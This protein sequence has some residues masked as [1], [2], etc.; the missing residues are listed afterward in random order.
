MAK[1]FFYSMVLMSNALLPSLLATVLRWLLFLTRYANDIP[2]LKHSIIWS[3]CVCLRTPLQSPQPRPSSP[4]KIYLSAMTNTSS[5]NA[6]ADLYNKFYL[7]SETI[8][9]PSIPPECTCLS[10]IHSWGTESIYFFL[11]PNT[12][13]KTVFT[14]S[15]DRMKAAIDGIGKLEVMR[16]TGI[17]E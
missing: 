17:I 15:I 1:C 2:R 7:R 11:I 13:K 12:W 10:E 3:K 6:T 5:L 9:R 14:C 8:M 16:L 4:V